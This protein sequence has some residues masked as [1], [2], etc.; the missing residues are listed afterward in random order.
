MTL[1]TIGEFARATGLTPKALRLYDGLGLVVPTQV[2][3][4]SGYRRYDPEQ[5]E[6]ARLVAELRLVGM[7]LAR[8]QAVLAQPPGGGAAAVASYWRQVEADTAS[9]RRIVQ[10]LVRRLDHEESTMTTTTRTRAA[11]IGVSHL[12]GGRDR[13][14]DAALTTA[15]TYAVADGFGDRDD[16]AALALRTFAAEGY[17]AAAAAVA[18]AAGTDTETGTTLSAAVLAGSTVTVTHVGD[19]RVHLVR[20]GVVRCL[21]HDHTIVAGLIATGDLTE[22]EARSHPHRLLLNRALSGRSEATPHVGADVLDVEVRPRDR[23]ALTTDGVHAVLTPD[24][25]TALLLRPD[26]ADAVA[27][28]IG[29]AVAEA[30]EPDN[31]TAVV[32]DLGVES[33]RLG[34]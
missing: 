14:Q 27:A 28:A 22:E 6:R 3:P 21:T 30:G 26:P 13:Q 5:I 15:D 9:R 4:H 24:V 17:D 31:H 1:L 20:D 7:P 23:L 12:P 8:I 18:I 34:R 29:A 2:D 11:R 25:L 16:L 19:A 10:A 33:G 32:V